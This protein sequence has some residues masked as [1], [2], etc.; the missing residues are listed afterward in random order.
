MSTTR[1][2][3]TRLEEINTEF[4]RKK[5]S[6]EIKMVENW[7]EFKQIISLKCCVSSQSSLAR[8]LQ[9]SVYIDQNTF[10]DRPSRNQGYKNCTCMTGKIDERL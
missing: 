4:A 8:L 9:L 6:R 7:E 2:L 10:S 3:L 1:T 5:G